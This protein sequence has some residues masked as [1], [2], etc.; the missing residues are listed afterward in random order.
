MPVKVII[1]SYIKVNRKVSVTIVLL[2]N[3][4]FFSYVI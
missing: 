4:S 2:S 1:R 3:S